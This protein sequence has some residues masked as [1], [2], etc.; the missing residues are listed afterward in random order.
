MG[1]QNP[2]LQIKILHPPS[3]SVYSNILSSYVDESRDFG[4]SPL[5]I[6]LLIKRD[7]LRQF[8]SIFAKTKIEAYEKLECLNISEK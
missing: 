1:F 5:Q 3:A 2:N 4:F 7:S 8:E 6:I